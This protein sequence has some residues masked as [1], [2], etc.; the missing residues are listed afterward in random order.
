MN[1]WAHFAKK[2]GFIPLFGDGSTKYVY[3]IFVEYVLHIIKITYCRHWIVRILSES[4]TFISGCYPNNH[5]FHCRIQPVYVV[6]VAA[7]IVAAL[8][9]DG[10]SIGKVYELG[11]PEIFTVHDLVCFFFRISFPP[12]K[13]EKKFLYKVLSSI[14][15]EIMF[16]TIREWP[17]YMKVPFPIAKVNK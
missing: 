4:V 3:H 16:D 12:Q 11:G 5:H 8:R 6:D 9:D 7:G 13:K 14:Q 17:R 15:A 10:T 2:Y 1:N